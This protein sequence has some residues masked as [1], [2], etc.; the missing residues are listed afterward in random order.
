MVYLIFFHFVTFIAINQF[1]AFWIEK[2]EKWEIG[3]G[4]MDERRIKVL[5]NAHCERWKF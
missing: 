4:E 5:W 1:Q 2:P 3:K